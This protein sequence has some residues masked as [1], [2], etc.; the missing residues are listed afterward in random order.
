V[1]AEALHGVRLAVSEAVTN[2]VLHGY[3]DLPQGDVT[4]SAE[5][6]DAHLRVVVTD[7]GVGLAPR[8][9][10]PGAGFGL[11]LIAEVADSVAVS[12]GRD[13]HGTVL[14]MTF[15]LAQAVTA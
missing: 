8:P 3:R 1:P 6:E 14:S 12:P 11:P 2:A 9:D 10:S 7:D 4:V 15:E 5:A 13:G